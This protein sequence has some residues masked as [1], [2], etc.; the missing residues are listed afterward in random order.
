MGDARE[1]IVFAATLVLVVAL[2]YA[3]L[4]D[5]YA[6]ARAPAAGSAE[7]LELAN[8]PRVSLAGGD[9]PEEGER[10]RPAFAPPRAV[11]LQSWPE[12]R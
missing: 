9:E 8:P 7:V 11:H 5:R 10:E 6:P 4:S 1:K 12:P 2:S 3:K